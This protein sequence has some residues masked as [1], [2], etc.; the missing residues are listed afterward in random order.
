M[1]SSMGESGTRRSLQF[2]RECRRGQRAEIHPPYHLVKVRPSCTNEVTFC[3]SRSPAGSAVDLAGGKFASPQFGR[4]GAHEEAICDGPGFELPDVDRSRVWTDARDWTRHRAAPRLSLTW[5]I[6]DMLRLT[7]NR[8]WHSSYNE[9]PYDWDAWEA[10]AE[11]RLHR[12]L[13]C[14]PVVITSSKIPI[15]C[16]AGSAI[17][18]SR[19]ML[20]TSSGMLTLSCPRWDCW[21]LRF[22]TTSSRMSTCRP[23][24][25][26]IR[27]CGMR[28]SYSASSRVFEEGIGN[29]GFFLKP[30]IISG[31]PRRSCGQNIRS[32]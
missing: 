1:L 11:N 30:L 23:F 13:K 22:M 32:I 15:L 9:D 26:S 4:A 20:S 14:L 12:S 28:P 18:S 17:P 19:L 10:P 3:R 24:A 25:T 21:T 8:V 29:E 16:G 2:S 31:R 27:I 5:V 6:D 7:G